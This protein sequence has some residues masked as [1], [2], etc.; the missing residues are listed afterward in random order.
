MRDPAR[1]LTFLIIKYK[2]IF[3]QSDTYAA[4]M[5]EQSEKP[6]AIDHYAI[7]FPQNNFIEHKSPDGTHLHNYRWPAHADDTAPKAVVC[8]L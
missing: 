7:H 8:M 3:F 1:I 5:V 2:H 6:R 4:D